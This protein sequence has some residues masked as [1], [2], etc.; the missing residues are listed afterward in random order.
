[1]IK[2][3]G[4]IVKRRIDTKTMVLVMAYLLQKMDCRPIPRLKLVAATYLA[5]KRLEEREIA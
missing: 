4:A 2:R 3:G 5:R 1:L